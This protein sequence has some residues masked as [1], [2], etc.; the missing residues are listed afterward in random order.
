MITW[1]ATRQ[2]RFDVAQEKS[3][4][5]ERLLPPPRFRNFGQRVTEREGKGSMKR[6]GG[7]Q[8]REQA[9]ALSTPVATRPLISRAV[10]LKAVRLEADTRMTL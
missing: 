8:S 1:V 4:A 3:P 5:N 2:L 10:A 6:I 7:G 9:R